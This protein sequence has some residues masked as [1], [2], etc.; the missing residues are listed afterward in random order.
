MSRLGNGGRGSRFADKNED[1]KVGA[2]KK[3]GPKKKFKE[4]LLKL[5]V[6]ITPSMKK[7]VDDFI[8]AR[9]N[10]GQRTTQA[11]LFR[12]ALDEKLNR[13]GF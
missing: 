3:P 8:L 4:G 6:T 13:E 12:E 1:I 7:R 5:P 11:D 10:A 9:A 2:G